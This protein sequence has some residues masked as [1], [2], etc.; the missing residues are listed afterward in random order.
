MQPVQEADLAVSFFLL[1]LHF[2]PVELGREE[3]GGIPRIIGFCLSLAR[4]LDFY[5][6]SSS[7]QLWPFLF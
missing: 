3:D 5:P 7:G 6:T 1:C 2:V 4:I